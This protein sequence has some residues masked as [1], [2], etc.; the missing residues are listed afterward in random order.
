MNV[1]IHPGEKIWKI[2]NLFSGLTY[3]ISTDVAKASASFYWVLESDERVER[4]ELAG[5]SRPLLAV[6]VTQL[7][8]PDHA[9]D[10]LKRTP[11]FL[12]S[13]GSFA[14]TQKASLTPL[15]N[16]LLSLSII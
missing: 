4:D 12:F 5:K 10:S 3:K 16:H 9:L 15:S 2:I 13:D 7:R 11:P 1:I 14:F 6:A 8:V